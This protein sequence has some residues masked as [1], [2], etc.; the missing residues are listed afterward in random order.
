V[1]ALAHQP[2]LHVGLGH[3][4]GIDLAQVEKA[5]QEFWEEIAAESETKARVVQILRDYNALMEKAG[6][7]YRYS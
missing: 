5:A 4:H 1:E 2:A 6:R 7:P 3:D